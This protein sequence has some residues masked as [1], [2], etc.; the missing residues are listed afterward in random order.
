[1]TVETK[2]REIKVNLRVLVPIVASLLL[3]VLGVY[4]GWAQSQANQNTVL[5]SEK[6]H[7]LETEQGQQDS[8]I[9]SNTF[10]ITDMKTAIATIKE[11]VD[12]IYDIVKD[13][14]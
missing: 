1:M 14:K 5:L 12:M 7:E 13:G 8:L 6:V 9:T 11:K 2:K 4:Y 3:A 10:S